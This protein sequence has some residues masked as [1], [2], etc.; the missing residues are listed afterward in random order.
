[1]SFKPFG[2]YMYLSTIDLYITYVS[3]LFNLKECC[4]GF[5]T[6]AQSCNSEVFINA[7]NENNDTMEIQ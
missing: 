3:S 7:K 1:M 5:N 2:L 4:W 6:N